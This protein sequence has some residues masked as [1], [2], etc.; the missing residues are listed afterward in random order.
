VP[1]LLGGPDNLGT[2][3]TQLTIAGLH[4]NSRANLYTRDTIDLSQIMSGH[5]PEEDV[6]VGGSAY[7]TNAS[8]TYR[9]A[10]QPENAQASKVLLTNLS[11]VICGVGS[12]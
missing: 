10:S 1:V 9:I 4:G 7:L 8:G 5:A 6:I 2:V 12:D 3:V 11:G